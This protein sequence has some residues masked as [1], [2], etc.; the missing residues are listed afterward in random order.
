VTVEAVLVEPVHPAE[1]G[2]FEF[3]DVVPELR[4]VGSV[5]AFGLAEAVGG[6]GERVVVGVGDRADRWSGADLVE[7]LSESR[8][9]ELRPAGLAPSSISALADSTAK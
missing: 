3:V 2:E 6:L 4:G 1:C 8:R 5:D 9:C 7:T